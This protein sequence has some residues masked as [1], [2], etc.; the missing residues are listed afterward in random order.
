MINDRAITAMTTLR[1]LRFKHITS[2]CTAVYTHIQ[3]YNIFE[4]RKIIQEQAK[5]KSNNERF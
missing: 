4:V 1:R 2:I 3:Y 5:S